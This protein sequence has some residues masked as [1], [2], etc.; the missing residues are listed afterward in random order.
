M[1]S[2]V[3]ELERRLQARLQSE[4]SRPGSPE[5]LARVADLI[6]GRGARRILDLGTGCGELLS[7]LRKEGLQAVGLDLCGTLLGRARVNTSP[8]TPLIQGDVERLPLASGRVD[9]VTLLR[10]VHYL[11]RPEAALSEA[12]R[13]LRPGG[14]L[15][16]ADRIAASE[17][18]LREIHQRIESLRNPSVR[19]LLTSQELGDSVRD[20]GFRVR[21]VE[22]LEE[23]ISLASWLAGVGPERAAR[24][25]EEL[26]NA[27]ALDL[28]GLRFEAPD[29]IRIRIDLCLAE[30]R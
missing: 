30:K 8:S 18:S 12:A 6:R 17:P 11:G 23:T 3:E 15:I 2:T 5:L 26:A 22:F 7:L 25:R 13:V 1:R 14:W 19:R 10:V 28:G 29:Q 16:L 4:E 24:I 20:A 27:P 9:L 21:L